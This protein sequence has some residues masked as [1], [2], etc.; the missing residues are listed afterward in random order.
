MVVFLRHVFAADVP[1]HSLKP[2][3]LMEWEHATFLLV[4]GIV[5]TQP[6]KILW[7]VEY[8]EPLGM[9]IMGL[10]MAR[11][12]GLIVNGYRQRV[13]AW[14]RA[15]SSIVSSVIFVMVGVA[16][17][18]AGRIGL[19]SAIFPVIGLFELFNYSRAMRDVGRAT[20]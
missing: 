14:M 19:E 2:S 6:G 16:Y 18:W 8:E 12:A 20:S 9:L 17:L 1:Y 11:L 15:L 13:T 3:R 5:L 10:G 7:L 4:F